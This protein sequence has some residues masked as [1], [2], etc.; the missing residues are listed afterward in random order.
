[1]AAFAQE[2][3]DFAHGFGDADELS[4]EAHR[5]LG[6]TP[7]EAVEPLVRRADALVRH[8]ELVAN[9][10]QDLRAPLLRGHVSGYHAAGLTSW[11]QPAT[12]TAPCSSRSSPLRRRPCPAAWRATPGSSRRSSTRCSTRCP[13]SRP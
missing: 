10:D 4:R 13:R 12:P 11:R 9:L 7:L 6:L 5:I 3:T 2:V 1:G 8:L